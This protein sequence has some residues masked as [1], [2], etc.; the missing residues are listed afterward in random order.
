M[1]SGVLCLLGEVVW[2]IAVTG[3]AAEENAIA[4]DAGAV[5]LIWLG[6]AKQVAR[7]T[8]GDPCGHPIGPGWGCS[9][10]EGFD[11]GIHRWRVVHVP[12]SCATSCDD[13]ETI[14]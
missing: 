6:V 12:W 8:V 14:F 5:D 1:F 2:R 4:E 10:W 7:E 3:T 9:C 13:F 11:R